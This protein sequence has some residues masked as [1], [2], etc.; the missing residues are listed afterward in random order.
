MATASERQL[1]NLVHLSSTVGELDERVAHQF[2]SEHIPAAQLLAV[3]ENGARWV[4]GSNPNPPSE[5][6]KTFRVLGR[7]SS[8]LLLLSCF[9][10]IVALVWPPFF[11]TLQDGT[12]WHMGFFSIFGEPGGSRRGAVNVSRLSLFASRALEEHPIYWRSESS[13]ETNEL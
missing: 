9:F 11:L 8:I 7:P 4:F 6:Y 12:S 2:G 3:R 1:L 13:E 5:I 10:A